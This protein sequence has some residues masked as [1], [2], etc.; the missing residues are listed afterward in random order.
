MTLDDVSR[1]RLINQQII[2]TQ[3][4]TPKENSR[5]VRS[6]T[7]TGLSD[8]KMGCRFKSI[9]YDEGGSFHR[10]SLF[11]K[12]QQRHFDVKCHIRSFTRIEEP[13]EPIVFLFREHH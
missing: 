1:I 12:R 6:H 7:G 5:L 11:S 10:N 9:K 2:H 8:G 3:F 4:S 13:L